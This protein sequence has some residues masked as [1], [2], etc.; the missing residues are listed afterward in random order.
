MDEARLLDCTL[1]AVTP[2][3]LHVTSARS[4]VPYVT[5]SHPEQFATIDRARMSAS[6]SQRA[7]L[8]ILSRVDESAGREYRV[9][10][11]S[12]HSVGHGERVI[13]ALGAAA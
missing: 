6:T 12:E 1:L 8:T 9:E 13:E 4:T 5:I 11:S 10:C 2:A 7:A 3:H